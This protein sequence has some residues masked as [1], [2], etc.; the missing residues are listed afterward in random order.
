MSSSE[1]KG[2]SGKIDTDLISD[3]VANFKELQ[4]SG[5]TGRYNEAETKT[6]FIEPLFEALGWNVRG[7]KKSTDRVTKE[8]KVSKG[9]ADYGFHLNEVRRFYLEAKSLKESEILFGKGYDRQAIDYSWY[10]SC[11]WAVLTNFS[12]LAVYNAESPGGN[13]IFT[14]NA[15]DFL[16]ENK[17]EY[18]ILSGKDK[19]LLLSKEGFENNKLESYAKAIGKKFERRSVDKQLLEDMVH[20]RG[21]LS[22]DILKYNQ[23]LNL[24]LEDIDEAVQR[25]LDRLIFIRNAEDRGMEPNELQSN[26]RIWSVQEKGHLIKRIREIYTTYKNTYNSGLFGQ[27]DRYKHISDI[28]DV[29]NEALSEVI[30]GLYSPEGSYTYDFSAIESDTLGI[31]Y[32]QYLGN[33]LRTT[34]KRAKIE[35]SKVHRKE[36]GIYYTPSYIVDYIVKNTVSEFIR[37]HTPEEI[38]NVKVLDP[39]CGSG[40]FLIRA[41]QELE[42]YWKEHSDFSQLI[43]DRENFYSKK[44]E[45]LK[46]NLF[47]VDLDPKAVEI[48]QLNLLLRISEKKQRLPILQNNIK[49]GNSLIEDL[50]VTD[51]AFKW[52]EQFS[53]IMESGG[54][55]IVIGNPPYVRQ[56]GLGKYKKYFSKNFKVYN[57]T[58][59]LYTYFIEKGVSLLREGGLFSYIVANKWMR[60]KYGTNLRD[61]LTTQGIQEIVDFG[62]LPIFKEATTYPCIIRI[63]KGQYNDYFKASK[64]SSMEFKNLKN[65]VTDNS[66]EV[67]IASLDTN[68]WLLSNETSH[69]LMRK[70]SSTSEPLGKYINNRIFYGIKTGLN[71]AFIINKQTKDIMVMEDGKNT[72][73]IKPFLMGRD[74]KRYFPL[75]KKKYIL[76]IPNGWTRSMAKEAPDKWKW[77][78]ENYPSVAD[79]LE[80]FKL[81]AKQRW[82]H[83]EFWWEL[84]PCDY[85]QEFEKPKIILSDI[86][87]RGNFTLDI[88]G[89]FYCGNTGYIIGS[90]DKYLL[91]ILNSKLITWYY[92]NISSTYRGGYLRFIYQYLVRLPIMKASDKERQT[93]SD[94]VDNMLALKLRYSKIESNFTDEKKRLDL[95]LSELDSRI[96]RFVYKLYGLTEKDIAMIENDLTGKFSD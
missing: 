95:E 15:D 92:R 80:K 79:H 74:V 56:E 47:G 41:Y 39:A 73:L 14:L 43:L 26:Y 90:D 45:I 10:K 87:L 25:I 88:E 36:Q 33:L 44:T 49:I 1:P 57:G 66:F 9:R 77:L 13:H 31:I 78:L 82:D 89:N 19:L 96:D 70:L 48:T 65:Y 3:L 71:E 55:D 52:K 54:F 83:G 59:D 12:T 8:E 58:S 2:K 38:K 63:Q 51:R 27:E 69:V 16:N 35:E 46:N 20:F 11:S 64:V 62:D 68:G 72:K 85:L 22:K 76:M 60:S 30:Q 67:K 29:S 23:N 40:S 17:G 4:Q 94:L 61:W 32:E 24:S 86:S 75:T 84:R 34:S 6:S 28:V 50:D 18:D 5:G 21:V 37:T 93:L 7:I 91:G 42:N 53:D 81:Q